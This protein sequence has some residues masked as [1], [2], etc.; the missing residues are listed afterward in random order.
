MAKATVLISLLT[1]AETKETAYRS[2]L[3]QT[4]FEKTTIAPEFIG[5]YEPINTP[6][7][8]ISEALP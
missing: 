7:N 2:T 1:D 8:D 3:L 4:L 5:H 6:V